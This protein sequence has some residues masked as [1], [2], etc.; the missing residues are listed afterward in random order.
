MEQIRKLRWPSSIY[1]GQDERSRLLIRYGGAVLA[2]AL[3]L[4]IRLSLDEVVGK[5]V[6]PYVTVYIAVVSVAWLL[7]P[8]PAMVTLALSMIG[9]LWVV[10]P[11]RSSLAIKDAQDLLD[12]VICLLVTVTIVLL[13]LMTRLTQSAKAQAEALV[14]E[15][16]AKLFETVEDLEHLSYALTHDMRAPLRSMHCYAEILMD[17]KEVKTTQERNE[18]CQRMMDSANRLDALIQDSLNYTKVL[19][20]QLT[21]QAVDL[22]RL[23]RGLIESYPQLA[24]HHA[25]IN[26]KGNLLS[27]NG[28][29]ALLTHSISNLLENALKFVAPGKTPLVT[30][31]TERRFDRARLWVED[32]GIGIRDEDRVRIFDMFQQASKGYSGTGMGLAIVRKAVERMGGSVGVLSEV[33]KGSR[34]WIELPIAG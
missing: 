34:F 4:G 21:N 13:I 28:N 26:I 12:I 11:P 19:R 9:C 7:G 6:H 32:N 1:V 23:I 31:W 30:I 10:V 2:A 5:E 20:Q 24:Q 25:Q 3:A 33:G 8:Q 18:I 29:V 15:R 27:V 17:P 16:T 14:Q 22:G